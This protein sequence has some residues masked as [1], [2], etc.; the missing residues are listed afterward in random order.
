MPGN[1]ELELLVARMDADYS[2]LEKKLGKLDKV[3]ETACRKIEE[4]Q[5]T[6]AKRLTAGASHFSGFDRAAAALGG[7]TAAGIVGGLADL[8]DKALDAAKAIADIAEQSGQ[9]VERVQALRF[10]GSQLG[11]TFEDVDQGLV[12][13][14]KAFGEFLNS[15]RGK[16]AVDFKVIGLDKAILSGQVRDV[17]A[18]LDFVLDKIRGFQSESQ[19]AGFMARFFGDEV[20]QKLL[21]LVNNSA[22]SIADLEAKARSLGLVMGD[23]TVRDAVN[24]KEKLAELFDVI[25]AEGVAAIVELAPQI[26]DLAQRLTDAMPSIIAWTEH[27]A[28]WFGL[29]KQNPVEELKYQIDGIT[30]EIDELNDKM[31]QKDGLQG[32]ANWISTEGLK[33]SIRLKQ[34]TLAP[35]LEQYNDAL[36]DQYADAYGAQLDAEGQPK[37]APKPKLHVNDVEGQKAA[38]ELAERRREMLAQLGVD[39]ATANAALAAADNA[40]QVKKLEGLA[41]YHAAALKQIEDEKAA[42]FAEIEAERAKQQE[43]LE[44]LKLPSAMEKLFSGEINA[45]A[46]TKTTTAQREADE[47]KYEISPEAF[48][49]DALKEGDQQIRQYGDQ[50]AALGLT[51]Y[52]AAGLTYIQQKLNEQ[53]DKDIPLTAEQIAQIKAK[54][55][56]ITA[57]AKQAD[58][59]AQDMQRN[60]QV[61]DSLRDGLEKIGEAG[62][63]GFKG[64]ADAAKQFLDQL[65]QTIIQ[66]YVIKPLI[67]GL[68]TGGGG[69]L[70][71]SG[72]PIGGIL[73][74]LLGGS[75]Y[76]TGLG[77]AGFMPG[78]D[79]VLQSIDGA[80]SGTGILSWLSSLFPFAAGGVMT[81]RG[82][83]PLRRYAGGGIARS[84]QVAVYGEKSGRPEAYVP[85]PDGR[86][87]PVAMH[88]P[89]VPSLAGMRRDVTV[90][91]PVTVNQS[92][93]GA[94]SPESIAHLADQRAAAMG[95]AFSKEL[96][97]NMPEVVRT[98]LRDNF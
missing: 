96:L 29:I 92:L 28:A 82:P 21:G 69:L 84:P 54:G 56:A 95:A 26:A 55:A 58:I 60:I 51:T 75:Q 7:L 78:P 87:I 2:A 39:T 8:G 45:T 30:G 94:M 6:L 1:Q 23:Q 35:L 9:S 12:Y 44:K 3:F 19:R 90:H 5:G 86:R 14:N 53:N 27:W 52:A 32:F 72:T 68:G 24:A 16:A 89:N 11:A 66:L 31:Q 49:K 10:A 50:T 73:G 97:R 80:G 76:G 71:P 91:A 38:E 63:H 46:K 81:A 25:K 4:R 17:G 77:T 98:T 65:A 36:E 34:K 18:A 64:M 42:K 61:S 48:T 88:M 13:F 15:G 37:P 33:K 59:A 40:L 74:Y 41:G 22:K 93:D 62:V 70:G 79:P 83:L 67:E 85:L 57:A 43:A 20:G 47:K